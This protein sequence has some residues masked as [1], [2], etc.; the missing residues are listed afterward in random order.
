MTNIYVISSF[1]LQNVVMN[2]LAT[3]LI[4]DSLSLAYIS[5][6]GLAGAKGKQIPLRGVVNLQK[7]HMVL[8][9][10]HQENGVHLSR[11]RVRNIL[12]KLQRALILVSEKTEY[13]LCL[14]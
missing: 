1:I 10:S 9:D 7:Q 2:S 6:S 3:I 11:Q 12:G 14:G 5:R 13:L 8:R 4:F